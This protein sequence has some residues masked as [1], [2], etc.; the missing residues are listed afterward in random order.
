MAALLALMATPLAA[1]TNASLA[2]QQAAQDVGGGMLIA[3]VRDADGNV[4][5]LRQSP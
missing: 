3:S 1:Q 2:V 4:T 5:G